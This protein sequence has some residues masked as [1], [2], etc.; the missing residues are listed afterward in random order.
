[1]AAA[2]ALLLLPATYDDPAGGQDSRWWDGQTWST[3]NG[4]PDT[5][6]IA[7]THTD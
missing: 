6:A 4:T 1:L 5:G 7:K 2:I 3:S